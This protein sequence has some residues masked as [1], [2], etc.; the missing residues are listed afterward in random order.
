MQKSNEA[1]TMRGDSTIIVIAM[2][3]IVGMLIGSLSLNIYLQNQNEELLKLEPPPPLTVCPKEQK[4]V[5]LQE[6]QQEQLEDA[7]IDE[8]SCIDKLSP[9]Q[10]SQLC[11]IRDNAALDLCQ[12]VT[13]PDKDKRI[14]ELETLL[15][16]VQY[17]LCIFKQ[18]YYGTQGECI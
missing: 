13:I 11:I 10:V 7:Q 4:S 3:A 14:E 18:T 16:D 12:F 15:N 6:E 5:Q 2:L 1:S 17:E 9:A 8:N